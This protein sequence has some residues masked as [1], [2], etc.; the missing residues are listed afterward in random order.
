MCPGGL[1][2]LTSVTEI[3]SNLPWSGISQIE[4]IVFRHIRY[5]LQIDPKAAADFQVVR[6]S[7]MIISIHESVEL[8]GLRDTT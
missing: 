2:S 7:S 8:G 6:K 4:K 1:P 3:V 5:F